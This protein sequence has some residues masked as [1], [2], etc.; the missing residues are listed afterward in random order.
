MYHVLVDP[1]NEKILQDVISGVAGVSFGGS[2]A[3]YVAVMIQ[4]GEYTDIVTNR[5]EDRGVDYNVEIT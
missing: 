2:N 3:E 1:R 5:L 4:K